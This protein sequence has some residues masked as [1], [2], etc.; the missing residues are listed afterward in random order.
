MSAID[1]LVSIGAWG[2]LLGGSAVRVVRFGQ[3]S[4]L[5]NWLL[6]LAVILFYH[7]LVLRHWFAGL[8]LGTVWET[9]I[10]R[11][12]LSAVFVPAGLLCCRFGKNRWAKGLGATVIVAGFANV[13]PGLLYAVEGLEAGNGSPAE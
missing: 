10:T 6:S 8:D 5:A 2:S 9:E 7:S 12:E 3:P 4:T 11:F 1:G 13:F